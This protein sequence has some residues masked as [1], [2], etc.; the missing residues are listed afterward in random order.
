[1]SIAEFKE[2]V[3]NND[4]AVMKSIT[5]FS[6]QLTGSRGHWRHEKK[7]LIAHSRFLE[8]ISNG[9]DRMNV[10][11]TFSFPDSHI[12]ELHALLPGSEKYLG[13]TVVK[14]LEEIPPGEDQNNYIL[15]SEDFNLRRKAINDNGHIVDEFATATSCF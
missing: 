14:T 9:Q 12:K 13:K 3:N 5:V 6:S 15:Q 2:K 10:F 1:M 8:I 11:L 4:E 7:K